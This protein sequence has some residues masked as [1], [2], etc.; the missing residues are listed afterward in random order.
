MCALGVVVPIFVNTKSSLLK[1]PSIAD[2]DK[3]VFSAARAGTGVETWLNSSAGKYQSKDA[4][5]A[6]LICTLP[7]KFSFGLVAKLASPA[8]PEAG[9]NG[10]I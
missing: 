9:K 8:G 1:D 3:A 4:V 7:A 2:P 5:P 10:G 6:F